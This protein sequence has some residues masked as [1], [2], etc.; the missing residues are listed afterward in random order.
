MSSGGALPRSR[1]AEV[2]PLMGDLAD[3][4]HSA[5]LPADL[6]EV[7]LDEVGRAVEVPVRALIL[8]G[9]VVVA[10]GREDREKVDLRRIDFETHWNL[11]RVSRLLA[12]VKE[13][14]KRQ[15]EITE[16]RNRLA[17]IMAAPKPYGAGL[18]T[19]GYAVYG[20]AVA[21]RVGGAWLEMAVAALIGAV[22]G[23]IHYGTV[24]SR[25]FDLLKS[26]IA[27]FT[28]TLL[29]YLL[30][31]VL[32]PFDGPRAVFGGMTLLVPA[33]VVTVGTHEIA[34]G[35][36]ES[37]VVR[38]GYGLLRF[39]MLAFGVGAA[40]KMWSLFGS[41]P[42]GVR[43]TPLPFPVVFA[44]LTVGGAALTL[45]LQ[46]R[47]KDVGWITGG[48]LVAFGAQE[49]TK[50]AFGGSGSPTLAAFVL[51]V[52]GALVAR[53]PGQVAFTV[54]IPGLLQLAPGFLGTAALLDALGERATVDAGKTFFEVLL[55]ALQLVTGLLL[56]GLVVPTRRS[57]PAKSA[58]LPLS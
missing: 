46:G 4:L 39:A 52:T 7:H 1:E 49:L 31:G 37:G 30:M 25:E 51:G 2:A 14:A 53:I 12:V 57:W 23:A 56:G 9:A 24:I 45:C 5:S 58:P 27:A 22:A 8:Q 26:F 13:L 55:V 42:H 41:P 48:V 34:H 44:V 11:T 32:P 54:V 17:G 36:L 6:V 3:A 21:A 35:A 43:A 28:G 18:V 47:R 40:F 38:T 15:V 50:L 19:L 29:A 20:C 16:G 10:V 33:M